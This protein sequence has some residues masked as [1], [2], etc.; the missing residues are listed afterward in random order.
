MNVVTDFLARAVENR[1]E[2]TVLW[3]QGESLTYGRLWHTAGG[4][5]RCLRDRG[6]KPGDRVA[7]LL[8]NGSAYVTAYFG[9]LLARGVAV[10]LNPDTTVDELAWVLQHC[11]PAVV[12]GRPVQRDLIGQATARVSNPPAVV[13]VEGGMLADDDG[14]IDVA[15]PPTCCWP[16]RDDIA[17]IIYT[18]GTSGRPKG[19]T[20]AHRNLVA[21]TR[22]IVQYLK[23]SSADAVFVILPFYYSYG[24]SLLLTHVA[25]GGRLILTPDF[26][27]LNR[28]LDVMAAQQATG[29]SG[30]P[31]SYA[32]LIHRSDFLQR[33]FPSLRYLTCAGGGLARSV[34]ERIRAVFPHV[35]LYLMY[36][37][38]EAS[39][40]LSSLMPDELDRKPG[41]IG[42]GIPGVTLRVLDERGRPVAPGQ[43]GEIV[44]QGEN[45]M[46][47]YW[48]DPEG[49][50]A[51]L[52]PEGLRTGDLATVDEDGYI[53]VVGRKSDLIKSGAYRIHPKEIE[54]VVLELPAV[55]EVAVVGMPDEML[56]EAVVAFVVS[57]EQN[58][59]VSADDIVAHC[60]RRLPRYK[61]VQRVVFVDSLPKTSSGKV[62]RNVLREQHVSPAC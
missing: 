42:R 39:A 38:T 2:A 58:G 16:E 45:I 49:T 34:V 27:F 51:V 59:P 33:S 36:G 44:A 22:S 9:T 11:S 5:A 47:G 40:R 29:F 3:E 48:N 37:Q 25:V 46:V 4:F 1:A 15:E 28:A 32:M 43:V 54:E 6:I 8:P 19:V 21:N 50:A 24:N 13:W 60:A 7:I 41:S 20:L 57:S 35:E 55:A 56:G 30:V 52:R 14:P 17:Q 61:R 31:S 18:S 62:R 10:G 23:L 53:Y 12:V 26:V